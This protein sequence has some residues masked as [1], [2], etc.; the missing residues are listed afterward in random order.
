MINCVTQGNN[1]MIPAADQSCLKKEKDCI[2]FLHYEKCDCDHN[3]LNY[4]IKDHDITLRIPERA[5][6]EGEKVHFEVGVAMYGPF[7]HPENSQNSF[8]IAD[9]S[10][11]K[12][13]TEGGTSQPH[14][15]FKVHSRGAKFYSDQMTLYGTIQ[16]NCCNHI[17]CIVK[18]TKHG[19]WCHDVSSLLAHVD[20]RPLQTVHEFHFYSVFNLATH[21]KVSQ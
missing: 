16:T 7:Y 10:S 18:H 17:F 3:A 19:H 12:H 5:V 21:R 13:I 9:H 4:V 15:V 11:S 14:Y 8:A 6:A 1:I 20:L 2:P